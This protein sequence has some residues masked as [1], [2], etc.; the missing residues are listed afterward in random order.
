MAK[1][2]QLP[3]KY[4]ISMGSQT[5]AHLRTGQSGESLAAAYLQQQ[6]YTL[7]HQNY[8]YRRAEVDIIAQKNDLLVFVEVKTRTTDRYGYPEEAVSS[9]KEEL[10]LSAAEAFILEEGWQQ[11]ARF[12]IISITLTSPPT[13]HH[14]EDAFH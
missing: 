14:I 4:K 6:G 7:L 3:A 2:P 12:D 10:L 9:R 1:Q 13:I 8:R 11:E 5:S